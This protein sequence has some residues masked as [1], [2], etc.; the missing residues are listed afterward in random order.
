MSRKRQLVGLRVATKEQ[1]R[2]IHERDILALT[3]EDIDLIGIREAARKAIQR[4][5]QTTDGFAL[6]LHAS[7]ARGMEPDEREAG[8]SYRECSAVM[9]RIAASEELRAI[10]L[11]GLGEAPEKG[12]LETAYGYILSAHG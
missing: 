4:V 1:A 12:A 5:T 10:V 8:L 9:E 6:V 11:S 3:M 2:I 7:V